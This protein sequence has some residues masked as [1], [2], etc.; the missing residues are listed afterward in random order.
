MKEQCTIPQE[1]DKP[2]RVLMFSLREA[3]ILIIAF[4]GGVIAGQLIFSLVM[5]LFFVFLF[6]KVGGRLK[7]LSPLALSYWWFG[8]PQLKVAPPSWKRHWRG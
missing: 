8:I 1:L 7:G 4:F 3:I 6:R 5:G 2:I